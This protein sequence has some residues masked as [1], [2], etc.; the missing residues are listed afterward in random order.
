MQDSTAANTGRCFSNGSW[1]GELEWTL[2]LHIYTSFTLRSFRQHSWQKK[3]HEIK[4]GYAALQVLALPVYLC[5]DVKP[6]GN[7]IVEGAT[8]DVENLLQEGD[9]GKARLWGAVGK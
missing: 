7:T 5:C 8:E 3:M 6:V 1:H 9:Y 4:L 2:Y